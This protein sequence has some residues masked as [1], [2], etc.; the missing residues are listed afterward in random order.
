MVALPEE[1]V[2]RHIKRLRSPACEYHP[3]RIDSARNRSGG[4]A[5][6]LSHSAPCPQ[7]NGARF[8]TFKIT[9]RVKVRAV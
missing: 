1:A 2:Y 8:Q 3:Q 7:S 6:E 4:N 5:K 9:P